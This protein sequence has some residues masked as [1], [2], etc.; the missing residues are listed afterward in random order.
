M[1][2][3]ARNPYAYGG[4]ICV[5]GYVGQC[6]GGDVQLHDPGNGRYP[7]PCYRDEDADGGDRRDVD[8]YGQRYGDGIGG[9]EREL[10]V[11]GGSA[12]GRSIQFGG[13]FWV[14]GIAGIEHLRIQSGV[15]YGGVGDDGGNADD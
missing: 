3:Y 11:F 15:D 6:D 5:H 7:D 4:G 1:R 12:G 9:T 10:H 2:D 14:L 13:E 8:G